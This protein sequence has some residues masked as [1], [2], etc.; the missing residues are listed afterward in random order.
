M[1]AREMTSPDN[2]DAYM[3]QCDIFVIVRHVKPLDKPRPTQTAC[4]HS[5]VEG[6]LATEVWITRSRGLL[7]AKASRRNGD[8]ELRCD[9]QHNCMPEPCT[10]YRNPVT[11]GDKWTWITSQ[12][13]ARA[14]LSQR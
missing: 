2:R 5:F 13:F 8:D 4:Q 14:F 9:T 3:H 6:H 12:L 10:K 11:D 7:G 1:Q